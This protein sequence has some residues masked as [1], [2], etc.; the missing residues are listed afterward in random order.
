[1]L[2][3]EKG[4][5]LIE[6]IVSTAILALLGIAATG[7][8]SQTMKSNMHGSETTIAVSIAQEKVE[9]LK[10]LHYDELYIQTPLITEEEIDI[11]NKLFKR[12]VNIVVE[13]NNLIKIIVSVHLKGRETEL[14]TYKGK[15]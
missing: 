9:E 11:N 15:Y 8:L 4:F 1:M 2:S 14:V 13:N 5:T 7:I 12:K 6:I 3:S 10:S